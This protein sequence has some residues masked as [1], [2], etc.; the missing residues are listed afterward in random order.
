MGCGTSDSVEAYIE[1]RNNRTSI[2]HIPQKKDDDIIRGKNPVENKIPEKQE[3]IQQSQPY[4][5][6]NNHK[7]NNITQQQYFENSSKIRKNILESL[8]REKLKKLVLSC[9]KRTEISLNDFR[10]HFKYVTNNLT[11]AEKAYALF[12]WMAENIAYDVKGYFSGNMDVTPES[13]YRNGYG[14]CSGYSRL[15]EYIGTFIGL[16]I[17]CVSGYAKGVGYDLTTEISGTNHEWNIIKLDG[18][19]YQ[20]DST[21]GAGNLNGN[22]FEKDFSEFYF[23]PEPEQFFASHFPQD[24]KWQLITPNLSVE[25]FAKRVKFYSIFYKYF[26]K[27]DSV[28]HTI[29]VKNKT[30][31]RFYKKVDKVSMLIKIYDENE[32]KTDEVKYYVKEKKDYVDLIYIFKHKG[33]YSTKIYTDDESSYVNVVEYN[34]ESLEEWGDNRFGFSMDDLEIKDKLQLESLSHTDLGFKAKNREKLSFRFRPDSNI[35]IK[36]VELKLEKQN[37]KNVTK[38][39]MNGKNLDIEV[40]FN[41]KGKYV[42]W[43]EYLDLN[44]DTI[45]SKDLLYYPIVEKDAEEFKEFSEEE[46][47]VTHSIENV[48]NEIK[49]KNISHKNQNIIANRIEKFE[50]ECEDKDISIDSFYY[51][52][53]SK[54]LKKQKKENNK[55]IFYFGFNEKKK[56]YLKFEFSKNYNKEN[57]IVYIVDYEGDIDIPF[58]SVDT[59]D[60]DIIL[61]DPIFPK[62]QIGKEITL[63]FKSDEV[64]EIIVTNRQR[65][66][67]KKN[68]DGIFEVKITPEVNI[69]WILKKTDNSNEG[70]YS[71]VFKLA[72]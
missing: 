62:L 39:Y 25:E 3:N 71:M 8:D 13:V 2:Q 67:F 59:Y 61:V 38:H 57:E 50:F 23:C 70:T 48:I 40:I 14:V 26:T 19:Y 35:K 4:I 18:V 52:N 66:Y 24:P 10:L 54:L 27:A 56:I 31:I 49:F 9:K 36:S 42:L 43:I 41:K 1:R 51:P 53:N 69:I 28:Y 11:N 22:K 32:E 29:K 17:I 5:S 33:K 64:N 58:S 21:W 30:I 68:E 46:M 45:Y 55:Y 16:D 47:M 15:F 60:N 72:K 34:F 6:L 20:I 12:Y 65:F 37:I 44:I 63:K 7:N